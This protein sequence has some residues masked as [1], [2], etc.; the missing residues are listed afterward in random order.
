MGKYREVH[1]SGGK[2]GS[3][4]MLHRERSSAS[5]GP[6][7]QSGPLISPNLIGQDARAHTHANMHTCRHVH[8]HTEVFF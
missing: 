7:P 6:I 1:K 3:G 5:I 8:T 4:E 2:A